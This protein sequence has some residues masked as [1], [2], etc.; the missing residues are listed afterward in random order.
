MTLKNLLILST[1]GAAIL[2]C[3][4][5]P[6]DADGNPIADTNSE[7]V[8]CVNQA[9]MGSRLGK[10]VCTTKAEREEAARVTREAIRNSEHTNPS[11]GGF[12]PASSWN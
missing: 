3:A 7:G 4:Q 6:M 2:G 9:D 10:R 11:A 5:T 12:T 1:F 8:I